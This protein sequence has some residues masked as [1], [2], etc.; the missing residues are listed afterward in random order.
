MSDEKLAQPETKP[1]KLII[2][3]TETY[4]FLTYGC[5]IL[6]WFLFRRRFENRKNLPKT[7]GI[8]LAINH[9]SFLDIPLVTMAAR[10]HVCFV[11][12]SS[13][14]QSRIMDFILRRCGAVLV[15]R[16]SSDR[17]AL[18]EMVEH[19]R[20]GDI[21]AV[22]PEGTRSSDGQMGEFKKG[23]L[24]VARIAK[25]PIMPVGIRGAH[26]AFSRHAKFPSFKRVALRFGEA[27]D[28][29][30]PDA[31]EKVEQAVHAM[32]GDGRYDSVPP[33]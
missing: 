28:S 1:R 33:V 19:L 21:L 16:G 7:G 32:V 14:T 11:A 31:Q 22:F 18:R 23:A 8:V 27:V 10:R 4:F 2:W 25:V 26:E 29:S 3:G 13:L 30:L 20:L 6:Y 17:A 5:S 24:H 9:Q 12:R 15:K